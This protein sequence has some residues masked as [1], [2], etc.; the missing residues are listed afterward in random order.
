[1]CR[2][3]SLFRRDTVTGQYFFF[4]SLNAESF[5][6]TVSQTCNGMDAAPSD[7][8][9]DPLQRFLVILC[10]SF[11]I[12]IQSCKL[13]HRVGIILFRRSFQPFYRIFLVD[14]SSSTGK[15][16]R[17]QIAHCIGI[18]CFR[19]FPVPEECILHFAFAVQII[20]KISLCLRIALPGFFR[21]LIDIAE[22]GT[23]QKKPCRQ[24]Y[25]G[26]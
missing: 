8:F 20:G 22:T 24:R 10:N 23:E 12:L 9:P 26:K 3:I 17:S 21:Q 14:R 25:G 7:S 6:V 13:Q 16:H 19:G 2:R 18:S 11:T 15:I 4:I 1:M 5:L